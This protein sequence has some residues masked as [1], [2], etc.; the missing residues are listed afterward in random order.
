M[1][2][3][4]AIP[5]VT[6]TLSSSRID[7]TV[8]AAFVLLVLLTAGQAV[9]LIYSIYNEVEQTRSIGNAIQVSFLPARCATHQSETGFL[10]VELVSLYDIKWLVRLQQLCVETLSEPL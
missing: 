10:C 3:F 5:D 1:A 6:L 7:Q 9:L 8:L 4:I 2:S